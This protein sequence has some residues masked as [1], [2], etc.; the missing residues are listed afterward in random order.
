MQSGQSN[1]GRLL[2]GGCESGGCSGHE[3]GCLCCPSLV[4]ESWRIPGEMLVFSPCWNL[5]EV[6]FNTSYSNR[7]DDSASESEGEPAKS[8]VAFLRVPSSKLPQEGLTQ[9]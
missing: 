1:N 5:E 9:V 6:G 3:A 2:T 7:R 8:K 4:P